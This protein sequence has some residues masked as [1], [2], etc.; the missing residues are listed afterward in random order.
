[1]IEL[2]EISLD[3]A[4]EYEIEYNG[5]DEQREQIQYWMKVWELVR[6]HKGLDK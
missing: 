4:Q 1:M 5:D 3:D 6:P 2:E